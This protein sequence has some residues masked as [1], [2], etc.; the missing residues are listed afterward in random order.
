M[1]TAME[2]LMWEIQHSPDLYIRQEVVALALV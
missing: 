1:E 2:V